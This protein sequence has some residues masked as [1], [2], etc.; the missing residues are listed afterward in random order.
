MTEAKQWVSVARLVRPQGRRGEV[1]AEILTDFPER[2]SEM[3]GAFLD[4][5][6]QSSPTPVTIEQS[7][8]HKGRIVLKFA[9]VDSISA[10]EELRGAE[11]VIP[12]EQ[13]IALG[14]DEVFIGDLIGCRVVDLNQPDHPAIGAIRDVIQQEKTADMLVVTGSDGA[15]HW[16][17]F[18]RAYLVRLDLPGRCVEMKL[19]TGLL[20]VNAPL[21]EEERRAQKEE[22][23]LE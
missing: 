21:N 10:A 16:V 2:F 5:G 22:A 18:A 1:L 17:P 7:W 23:P 14:P 15:E 19:P 8:L 4:R 20:E 11:V 9:N 13:R 3:R 6:K 12:A